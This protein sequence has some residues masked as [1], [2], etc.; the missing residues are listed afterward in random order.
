MRTMP[1][2]DYRCLACGHEFE[3]FHPIS[4]PALVH[5]DRLEHHS[6]TK[7]IGLGVTIAGAVALGVAG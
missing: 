4:Q 1:T 7:E 5:D 2:Y 6:H 3:D